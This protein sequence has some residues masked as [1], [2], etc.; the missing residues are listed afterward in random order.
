MRGWNWP[1]LLG[2]AS[3]ILAAVLLFRGAM[4]LI[5]LPLIGFFSLSF[6]DLPNADMAGFVGVWAAFIALVYL[7][8]GTLLWMIG[9][10]LL[11]QSRGGGSGAFVLDEV[12]TRMRQTVSGICWH[13][14][15]GTASVA[16]SLLA[17]LRGG[18]SL[19][20]AHNYDQLFGQLQQSA[21]QSFAQFGQPAPALPVESLARMS[22][23]GLT[24]W[25]WFWI[26]TG[27]V[28]AI[29][30]SRWGLVATRL[31]QQATQD[32]DREPKKKDVWSKLAWF[33]RMFYPIILIGLVLE[34]VII[35]VIGCVLRIIF[36][37]TQLAEWDLVLLLLLATPLT[38]FLCERII[39]WE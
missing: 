19:Y 10:A 36:S 14:V 9:M 31:G 30:A 32:S 6:A 4:T 16:L 24:F 1:L 18:F 17:F 26:L 7:A 39:R 11:R 38:I 12:T 35:Y 33:A 20:L 27:C 28:L 3:L 34:F 22:T 2:I 25:G 15:A 37:G 21:N 23:A 5:I 13:A 8:L 29:V